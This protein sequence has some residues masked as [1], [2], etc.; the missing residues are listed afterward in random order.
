MIM[1]SYV[2]KSANSF[3]DILEKSSATQIHP[4]AKYVLA[5][6]LGATVTLALF[7]TMYNL[8]KNDAVPVEVTPSPPMPRLN[9]EPPVL[10]PIFENPEA[11]VKPVYE[12]KPETID[13]P[14]PIDTSVINTKPEIPTV[15]EPGEKFK[16]SIENNNVL[17]MVRVNPVYPQSLASRGVE[18]FVDV[19]FDVTETGS[20]QNIEVIYAEPE[21][22]FN[23]AVI[24][25]VSRWKYKPKMEDGVAVK[26]QGVRERIRFN[27]A[28]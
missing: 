24:R 10:D 12:Q 17:P 19:V 16:P 7:V 21:R 14:E 25:A 13:D 18:G 11:P 4:I 23:S 26:M 28:K 20:T 9:Q 15:F 6:T 8:V 2:L 3:D 1:S 27:L 22:V 5:I